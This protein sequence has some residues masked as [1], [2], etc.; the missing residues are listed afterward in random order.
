MSV[1]N[2]S[3]AYAIRTPPGQETLLERPLFCPST[4][5][6]RRC[7]PAICECRPCRC[8]RCMD[9]RY[10]RARGT[11]IPPVTAAAP[12]LLAAIERRHPQPTL[13]ERSTTA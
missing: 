12:D 10:G 2:G 1:R 3:H 13:F 4:H 8:K 7:D 9:R 11:W 5:C 6:R